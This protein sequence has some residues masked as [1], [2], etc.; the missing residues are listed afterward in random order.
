MDLQNNFINDLTI[1]KVFLSK[2]NNIKE[3]FPSILDDFKKYYII[4]HKNSNN[5]EVQQIFETIKGNL[6]NII[7]ELSQVTN[8]IKDNITK[9]NDKLEEINDLILKE[10]T[11]NQKLKKTL[12]IIEK[13]SNGS[14][15]LISD[16]KEI[17]NLNYLNNF[18]LFCGILLLGVIISLK[19]KVQPQIAKV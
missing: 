6:Q 18:S 1:P 4:F 5:N 13:N 9:L 12:G 19:F 11:K 8:N 2:I 10:K 14:V 17:Y 3:K 7:S 15:E 16:Y